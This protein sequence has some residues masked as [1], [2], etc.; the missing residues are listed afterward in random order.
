MP[1]TIHSFAPIPLPT[2]IPELTKECGQGNDRDG[3]HSRCSGPWSVVRGQGERSGALGFCRPRQAP[4]E[5]VEL[6]GEKCQTEIR[7]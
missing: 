4:F 3:F 2:P 1:G 7:T 6:S 5:P